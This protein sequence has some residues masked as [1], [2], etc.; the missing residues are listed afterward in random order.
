[1]CQFGYLLFIAQIF[2][3]NSSEM[4]LLLFMGNFDDAVQ[5]SYLLIVQTFT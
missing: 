2:W 5:V 3:Y 1:M 4:V